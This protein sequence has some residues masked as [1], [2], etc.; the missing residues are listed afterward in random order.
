[1]SLIRLDKF[2]SVALNLSRADTKRLIRDGKITVD[3]LCV[4]KGDF[5]VDTQM[6]TVKHGLQKLEYKEFVYILMNKPTGILS[7]S[8]DKRAKTVVDIIPD[9]LRREGLF[10]VGRLDKDTTGFLIITND[11]DFA[12]KVISPKSNIEK[13]YHVELDGEITDE[14]IEAFKSGVVLADGTQCMSAKLERAGDQSALITIREGKY[15]QVKRMFGTVGLGVNKL[16]RNSI[17]GLSLPENLEAGEC[18]ELT[19]EELQKI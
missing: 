15:H 11:G 12:H 5:K 1:M 9:R 18:I 7:A 10:P 13:V 14:M 6:M 3:G 4:K 2:V 17:G 19:E 16:H 8:N